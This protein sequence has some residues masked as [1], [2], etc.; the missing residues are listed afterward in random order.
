VPVPLALAVE[1]PNSGSDPSTGGV[2]DS[3]FPLPGEATVA[4]AECCDQAENT[5]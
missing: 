2:S 1:S 4:L 3:T 5:R